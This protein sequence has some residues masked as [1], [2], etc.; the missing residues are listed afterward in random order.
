MQL[1]I[2]AGVI[3]VV[4]LAGY[5]G[6]LHYKLWQRNRDK[7]P[8]G[9]VET[10]DPARG[11]SSATSPQVPLRKTLFVL[12]DA[13]INE[14]M[15]HTE[16]CLRICAMANNLE[17]SDLFRQEYGVLFRV[18]EATAHFPILDEWQALSRE[19]QKKFTRERKEIESR[20]QEAVIEAAERLRK[21]FR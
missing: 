2:A 4:A 12:A 21:N 11:L 13:L 16:G 5:A 15:T 7:A 10:F 9:T 3:V 14:K 20:Y 1:L 8:D 19:E 6:W 18:A 17:D